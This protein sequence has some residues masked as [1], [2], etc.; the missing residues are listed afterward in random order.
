MGKIKVFLKGF[1]LNIVKDVMIGD[2]ALRSY[3]KAIGRTLRLEA[4]E[5]NDG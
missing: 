5:V 4:I 3:S 2:H 1:K